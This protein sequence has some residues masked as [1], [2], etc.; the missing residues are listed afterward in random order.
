VNSGLKRILRKCALALPGL[1]AYVRNAENLRDSLPYPPGHYHSPIP[2]IEEVKARE[3]AIWQGETIKGIAGIDLNEQA[4]L[5]L[6]DQLAHYYP[7]Q[8]FTEQKT[9][10]LRYY[11]LND[12][13]SFSDAIFYHCM[14]RHLKP[15]RVI[16]IGIGFS[17]SVLL[18][19]NDLFF[20]SAI[21]CTFIDPEPQRLYG[22]LKPEDT[23]KIEVLPK[24]LQDVGLGLFSELS[25]GDIL[26][27]DSSHVAKTGSDV[28][29]IFFEILQAL[30]PGVHVHIHDVF[31]PFEYP[32]EYVYKKLAWNELYLLK[33]FLCYNRDFRITIFPSFLERFH[34][35]KLQRVL[36]LAWRHPR[37]WPT[38]RGAS[39]W[40]ERV[41]EKIRLSQ[42]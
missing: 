37:L 38:L 27:I 12:C 6:L 2:S 40:I 3:A 16:E 24:L 34:G 21:R 11:F 25:A 33:A 14:L 41:D 31:Y 23:R 29:L 10:N 17:S 13:F 8:P 26:F 9:P 7:R 15:K 22:L 30:A 42:S 39:L 19:T 1:G 35:E 5:R 18:D 20:D 36:P 28:N 4:Q 32:R